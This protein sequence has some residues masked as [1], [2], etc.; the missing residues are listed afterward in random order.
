M[1]FS[2]WINANP[3][4]TLGALVLLSPVLVVYLWA[5]PGALSELSDGG[6][7]FAAQNMAF[8]RKK[9]SDVVERVKRLGVKPGEM[10]YLRLD[11][12]ADPESLHSRNRDTY[13]RGREAGNVWASRAPTGE[14]TVIVVT[15]D[16]G[17]AG[18]LGYGYSETPPHEERG[19]YSLDDD[20]EHSLSCTDL[21]HRVAE[22]WWEVWSCEMD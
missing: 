14:F 21:Q 19:Q 17:H 2:D 8:D 3:W 22:N 11:N 9:M 16:M 4:K 10:I 13:M 7:G 18:S 6:R 5:A 12:L 1:K 15:V 20:A